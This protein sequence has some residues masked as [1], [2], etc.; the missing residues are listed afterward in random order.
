M[1]DRSSTSKPTSSPSA[2][3]STTP[4]I[5][6]PTSRP[7]YSSKL[8][9]QRGR[10]SEATASNPTARQPPVQQQKAWTSNKNPITGRSQT[11]QNNFN[12]Q[13]KQSATSSLR[14]GQRVRITLASGAEFEGTYNNGPESTSCR[15][16]MVQQKKSPNSADITNGA[17]RSQQ[18][19]M[20][21]QRKDIIDARV[22]TGNAG[23]VDGKALNGSRSSFRTDTAISNT[24]LGA[25]RALKPWVPESTDDTE[26]SLEKANNAGW[27]QFAE[28]ERLFGLKSDYDESIYTTTIDKNHPQHKERMAAAER[29]AREIERSTAATAHVAEERIM[30]FVGGADNRDEEEKYS[31]VRRQDFPP[32]S[33]RDLKY[34]PPARRAPTGQATVKG[35][36][37][38][39]AIISSQLKVAPTPAQPAPKVEE[40]KVAAQVSK[41]PVTP[42]TDVKPAESKLEE[43]PAETKT[44][45]GKVEK[46]VSDVKPADKTATPARPS[47]ATS[48]TATPK[49]STPAPSATSTVERD[50]LK[51]F[52]SFA[53]QQ[54]LMTEKVRV[55]KAKADKEVKLIELKNFSNTFKLSTPVPKD[56]ISIIAK[57]P[58]KQKQIQ[59]KAMRNAEEIA[60]QKAAEAAQKEKEAAAAAAKE[61]Q[62]KVPVEPTPTTTAA[63]TADPRSAARP[64]APQQHSN[65]PSGVPS[66]HPGPRASY[67]PQPHYQRYNGNNNRA[68]PHL[69]PPTQQTGH[70]AQRIREQQK[71]NS[72]HVGQHAPVQDMR[73]PPTGPANNA[74]PSFNRRVSGFQP[75]FL[76]NKLNPNSN[77]FRPNAFAPAFLPAGPSQGSSPRSSVNN[78]V[79]AAVP[80]APV[81]GQ[82]IRRKT[83]A[84]DIKKCLILSHIETIQPAIPAVGR[85]GWDDNDGLRPSYDTLPTW[86]QLQ[87]SEKPDSTM[88]L[89]YKEYF[90]KLPLSSAAVATPNPS[91]SMPQP[92][93]QHQLPFHLQHGAN[94]PP[95]QS[96]H[97]QPMQMH[98]GQHAHGPHVPYNNG[99]DHRMMHS[100]SAQSFASPR[101]T[102][103]PMAYP[104]AMG[105]PGQMQYTQPVMQPYMNPGAPQ[106]GQYRSFSNNP[107]FVPQQPHHMGAPM[108]MQTQFM[109][110]PNGMVP[111]GPQVPMYTTHPQFMTAGPVPPQPM[112]GSNGF[113][114][115]G[116]PVATMMAHQ[117]S[118]QGQPAGYGMSPGMPYQQPVYATQQPQGKFSGQRP[119]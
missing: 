109:S 72:P 99:D 46:P 84:V 103:V 118:H 54:R 62:T 28:N 107:Q 64:S 78:I 79:E 12:L 5:K 95:R 52:K 1:D 4:D 16:T 76:G 49:E 27:D 53:T 73:P 20:S 17:G 63:T 92:P 24:R 86:R 66:R 51:S 50:V 11:P 108:M 34:T 81:A 39:P 67:N 41:T 2:S 40:S 89:T 15:L 59:E 47:A 56:L 32:L 6:S 91:H 115:P 114:S 7:S 82:L 97:L 94:M 75:S 42:A 60:K 31:G 19:T 104:P 43:K 30:D 26:G 77:E 80:P 85:K 70:L 83:K 25:E 55:T 116:R 37:V 13:S 61:T 110:G 111:A 71:M 98:A 113:P 117:G 106:M 87:D 23:K 10:P 33:T 65:S 58:A 88:L 8:S 44:A 69:A 36:P 9:D 90:E 22:L 96:P 68:P 57:D 112:A 101:M 14:E 38:D 74:D 93:H 18:S 35:A 119:Q 29:K 102:Q 3:Q 105:T 48:R 21:F 45:A 100:N